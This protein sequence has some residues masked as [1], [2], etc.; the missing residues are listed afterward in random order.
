MKKFIIIGSIIVLCSL[1]PLK[2]FA[3]E[4]NNNLTTITVGASDD[5]SGSLMYAID[6]DDPNAFGAS[7]EFVVESGTSH[8]V[9]VKDAAGN[10]S[11][12]LIT[13]PIEKVGIEVTIGQD[14]TDSAVASASAGAAAGE[15]AEKGGG[16]IN[17]K[18]I[19]DGS[20]ESEK[21]FY[22]ITTPDEN[23]F[24]MVIDN[25]RS[26]DNVYL[27]NQ[28]TEEDLLSLVDGAD[29]KKKDNGI[30]SGDDS[31]SSN[32][33]AVS[34]DKEKTDEAKETNNKS[35]LPIA[36]FVILLM[37]GGF[38]YM[39]FYKPKK[40][41]ELDLKDAKDMD[42]FEAE[43]DEDEEDELYFEEESQEEKEKLLE[44]IISEEDYD[45][46]EDDETDEESENDELERE[47]EE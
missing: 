11:S 13:A 28:V 39:K 30:F 25:T 47:G 21:I 15:A 17:E 22:T 7:N 14:G 9:Y 24:Y 1:F 33:S 2:S 19:T 37:G 42:E 20:S 43:E 44:S 29:A 35:T 38:Y 12:Q 32:V 45:S 46:T 34:D 26:Q 16:T 3:A 27:L 41:A 6:S 36:I 5:E 31:T 23:V 4:T 18:T 10:I 40:E 8:T